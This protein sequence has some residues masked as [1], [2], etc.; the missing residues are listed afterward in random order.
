MS[1]LCVEAVLVWPKEKISMGKPQTRIFWCS[2]TKDPLGSER[3]SEK[4]FPGYEWELVWSLCHF[5]H[6]KYLIL[7]ESSLDS[8]VS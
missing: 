7:M 6:M 8:T 2:R 3:G 4:V 5:Q 1:C